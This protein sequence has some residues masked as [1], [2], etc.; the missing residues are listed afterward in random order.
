[1][2]KG[3][4]NLLIPVFIIVALIFILGFVLLRENVLDFL[5][6][7]P[8][9][10]KRVE[11][12]PK[13]IKSSKVIEKTRN[14]VSSKEDYDK[15]VAELF[16]NPADIP[17]P[18]VDFSSHKILIVTSETNDTT[19]YKVK[20]ESVIKNDEAQNLETI[21][22][23]TKP[24]ETCVNTEEKNVSIDMVLLDRESYDLKF[25]KVERTEECK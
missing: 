9:A 6:P 14:V 8:Y 3:K 10:M 17:M 20:I 23:H 21:I 16:D 24:G 18:A 25:D 13:N 7:Y 22:R 12:Y 15:L 19:G 1:M 2:K 4:T 11:G 5:K